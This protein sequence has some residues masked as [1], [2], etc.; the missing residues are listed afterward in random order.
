MAGEAKKLQNALLVKEQIEGFLANLEKLKAEGSVAQEQYDL[1][2][3]DYDQRLKSAVSEVTT[4]KVHI[5]QELEKNQK[6]SEAYKWELSKLEARYKVGE[7]SL[8]NYTRVDHKLRRSID[9]VESKIAEL[10]RLRGQN[11]QVILQA[12]VV[13][14]LPEESAYL[15]KH[16]RE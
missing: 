12:V 11:P 15:V 5:S 6:D 9:E 7:L 14:P 2:K 8:Q 10:K 4:L 13:F 16:K 1:L 3:Q